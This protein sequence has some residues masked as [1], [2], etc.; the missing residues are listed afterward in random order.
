MNQTNGFSKINYIIIISFPL[1]LFLLISYILGAKIIFEKVLLDDYHFVLLIKAIFIAG[2]LIIILLSIVELYK[3]IVLIKYEN[4]KRKISLEQTKANSEKY[5]DE[6]FKLYM[7]RLKF[8]QEKNKEVYAETKLQEELVILRN[9]KR[10]ETKKKKKKEIAK[11]IRK[12]KGDLK[13]KICKITELDAE[14]NSIKHTL[15]TLNALNAE[16]ANLI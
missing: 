7:I 13:I 2:I 8:I 9:S 3:G 16:T 15:D 12:M 11:A 5:K 4:E 14:L 10:A 1:L 6:E